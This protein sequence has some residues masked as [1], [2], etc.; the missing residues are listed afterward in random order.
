[1]ARR[2]SGQVDGLNL[3]VTDTARFGGHIPDVR[4]LLGSLSAKAFQG[5]SIFSA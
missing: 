2:R 1:M 5:P 3:D 4:P